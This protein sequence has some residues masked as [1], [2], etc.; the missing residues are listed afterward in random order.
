ML[1]LQEE[2]VLKMNQTVGENRA[3]VETD[4]KKKIKD[5]QKR[6]EEFKQKDREVQDKKRECGKLKQ[7]M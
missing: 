3:K 4:Y 7:Q 1:R 2:K 6:M 5:L